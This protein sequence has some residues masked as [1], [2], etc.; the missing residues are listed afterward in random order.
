MNVDWM[1]V[2]ESLGLPIKTSINTGTGYMTLMP[3]INLNFI[4][5][6]KCLLY[7]IFFHTM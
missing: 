3:C 7:C 1:I 6:E 5:I 4:P 2:N